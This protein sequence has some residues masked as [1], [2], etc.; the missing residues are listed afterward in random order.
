[1]SDVETEKVIGR[2][3]LVLYRVLVQ[4]KVLHDAVR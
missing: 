3:G 1:M 4:Y 2:E